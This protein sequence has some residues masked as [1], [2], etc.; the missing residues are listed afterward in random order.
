MKIIIEGKSKELEEFLGVE[1]SYKS[2]LKNI[3]D[4]KEQM[5]QAEATE[6]KLK[7]IVEK[8]INTLKEN[9]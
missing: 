8:K 5:T 3:T 7:E 1:E 6:T 9:Y 4:L 2:C